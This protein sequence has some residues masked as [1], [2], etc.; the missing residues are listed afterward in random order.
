MEADEVI[1]AYPQLFYVAAA[2]SWKSLRQ[3][4]LCS[5]DHIVSTGGLPFATADRLLHERRA[6]SFTFKHPELG[7]VTGRDHKRCRFTT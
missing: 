4:G 2:G 5:A 6:R 3:C 1:A 7:C